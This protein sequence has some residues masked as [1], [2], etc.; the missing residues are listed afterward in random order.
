MTL[1]WSGLGFKFSRN[2]RPSFIM[3]LPMVRLICLPVM[4]PSQRVLSSSSEEPSFCPLEGPGVGGSASRPSG[5]TVSS[6]VTVGS[7]VAFKSWVGQDDRSVKSLHM[8]NFRDVA[9]GIMVSYWYGFT[10]GQWDERNYRMHSILWI[11][12]IFLQLKVVIHGISIE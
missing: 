11:S 8:Y 1:G 5:L 4:S 6:S 10:W 2:K 12:H 3:P 9:L 7:R